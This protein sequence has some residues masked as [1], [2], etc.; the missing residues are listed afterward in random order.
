MYFVRD[1]AEYYQYTGDTAFVRK[2]W[3]LVAN[4]L[5][6]SASQVDDAGL[7]VTTSDDGADW[8]YYDGVK[9]GEVTAYNALYYRTLLDGAQLAQA[10]GHGNLTSG[11][12][13]RAAALKTAINTRLFDAGT[14]LYDLS[15]SVRTVTAQDANV[16]AV[17]FG[18]AP[19]DKVAG[20]L[21]KIKSSLWTASG[22]LPFSSGYQDTISPFVSGFELNARLRAGDTDNALQLLS[23]EWGPMIAPGDL[24]TGTFWENESTT[25]TQASG[26]TSMAHGWSSMPTS[27]LSQ[28]VLGIAPVD[29]GYRTWLVQPHASTLAWVEGQAPTPY[30]PIAVDWSHNRSTG[31][32]A[33]KV[34]APAGTAGT[35]AVPTFGHSVDIAVNGHPVWTHGVAVGGSHQVRSAAGAGDYVNLAVGAGTYDIATRVA[36]R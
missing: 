9:T 15:D 23:N 27:A 16:L 32:F 4:E 21:A 24:Y 33:M 10:A 35:I 20:I 30:G 13:D 8:D 19:A 5:A 12:T 36:T 14:G 18:I 28:Y 31:A 34:T 25:G 3:P 6:W 26:Q 2:E 29:A 22:T 1:L 7:F 11:Y 17:E